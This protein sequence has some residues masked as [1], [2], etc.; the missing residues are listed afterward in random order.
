MEKTLGEL[1]RLVIGE[2]CGDAEF[3]I[4]GVA[5]LEEAQTHEISF[6]VGPKYA[7]KAHQS[8]AGALIVP[9]G[10]SGIQKP[11]IVSENP[12]LAFAK[13]LTLFAPKPQPSLGV[14]PEAFLGAK[15]KLGDGVSIHPQV[16]VGDG[17][18]LGDRVNLHAGAHVGARVVIGDDTVI[19]PNVTV[20][21]RCVIGQRVIIHSGTVVGS[22]GFGFAQDGD[23]Y[24][25]I[26]QVGIVQIDDD[27][28]I[29]ANCTIDRATMGKTWIQR[30]VKIDNLVQVAHNVVVGENSIIIAQVG[31]SGST[32]LGKNVILAGQVGII[33]HLEIGDG[34]QVGAQSGVGKSIPAGQIV[35][36]SPAIPHRD[37]L[38]NCQILSRLPKLRK[39]IMS[40]EKRLAALEQET[41]S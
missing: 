35:S 25:K 29:G 32:K 31:I 39:M 22:D 18:V 24:F 4:S 15:V 10:L 12:Y 7:R 28:E 1:A 20:L 41:D 40:M 23:S 30:G 34:V 27:V 16:Y 37:W 33:G 2:L 26:P 19:Y 13:V 11:R 21:D 8:K 5:G 3:K 17:A 38:K 14:S 36:G 6:V 9:P